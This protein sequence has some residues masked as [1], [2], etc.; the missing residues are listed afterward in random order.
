[1]EKKRW[2][3]S[4]T[5]PDWTDVEIAMRV[6]GALHSGRVSVVFSP[7]G[8]GGNGGLNT[9]VRME[10]DVLPGSSIPAVVNVDGRFPCPDC[11]TLEGHIFAGVYRLDHAIAKEFE[12][13]ELW[14]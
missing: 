9:S 6:L 1:M 8:L 4:S 11:K 10:F 2:A 5:G 12:N 3:V 14:K 7:S 13:A